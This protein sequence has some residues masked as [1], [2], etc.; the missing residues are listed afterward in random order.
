MIRGLIRRLRS[1]E[2][3]LG[4]PMS[5]R[6]TDCLIFLVL[7]M[8]QQSPLFAQSAWPANQSHRPMVRVPFVGCASDGQVGPLKAPKGTS[9]VLP[10]SPEMALRLAY[11]KAEQGSGI[12]APRGW[13]CF[14]TYGSNGDNLY[15]S[16]KPIDPRVLFSNRWD[17]FAR[18]AIQISDMIGDT[19]GR[20]GLA[21]VKG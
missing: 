19:S 18:A 3:C 6:G 21:Q 8:C 5:F 11:Y 10:I 16:P 20:F 15:V 1:V 7:A 12:L 2:R 13:H 14:G 17:G 4:N 9:K